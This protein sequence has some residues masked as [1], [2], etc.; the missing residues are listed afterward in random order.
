MANKFQT[1]GKSLKS[2]SL[3]SFSKENPLHVYFYRI[4]TWKRGYQNVCKQS[5]DT[6]KNNRMWPQTEEEVLKPPKDYQ[7]KK[8]KITTQ[9]SE[10]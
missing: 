1:E 3:T 7:L 8:Q 9:I 10:S 6:L 4:I 5:D 2:V